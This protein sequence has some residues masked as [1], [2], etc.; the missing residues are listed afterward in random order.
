VVSAP[1]Q[2]VKRICGRDVLSNDAVNFVS[3]MLAAVLTG[4]VA[5]Y[6]ASLSV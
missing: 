5:W 4:A 2:G 1:G 6:W 3:A